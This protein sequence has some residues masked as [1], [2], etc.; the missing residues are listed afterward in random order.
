M[1]F[2]LT[3]LKISAETP[4]FAFIVE[5]GDNPTK[6]EFHGI[7]ADHPYNQYFDIKSFTTRSLLLLYMYETLEDLPPWDENTYS[8][9]NG[10]ESI[11]GLP[12]FAE[13]Q[14]IDPDAVEI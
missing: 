3:L 6:K 1:K 8:Q 13:I 5:T 10:D 7:F 12:P 2:W 14:W 11:P 9:I 4:C